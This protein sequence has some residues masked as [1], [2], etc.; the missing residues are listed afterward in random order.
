LN[1]PSGSCGSRGRRTR[2]SR[3]CAARC[4]IHWTESFE[5][6]PEEEGFWSVT[7]ADD[8]GSL[9]SVEAFAGAFRARHGA[10]GR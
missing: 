7:T 4:P 10:E 3:R 2:S 8:L 5:E 9:A 6:F 1:S